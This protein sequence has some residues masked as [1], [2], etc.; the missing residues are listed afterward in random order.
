MGEVTLNMKSELNCNPKYISLVTLTGQ[1]AVLGLS[2]RYARTR[3][4]DMFISTTA[5]FLAEVV[6]LLTCLG[7]VWNA[8]D[9]SLSQWWGA[10]DKTIIKQ[11]MDTVKVMVPSAV[12]LIQNNLLYVAASNLDV[13]T[14][15]ITYQLKI[16]TTAMF[17]VTMLGKK[18]LPTQW[19]SLVLLV[20]GVAMVQLSDVKEVKS[21]GPDQSKFVGFSAALT[22]CCLSGFAGVYFEKILKG[23]D[24]SVW[25]RNVQMALFA[26]P[27]GLLSSYLKDATNIAE[28]GFM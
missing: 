17:A 22:A 18:L 20:A 4:G 13:A 8:E 23:S 26:V 27:M 21:A 7:L 25:M 2:M 19:F 24:V 9:R 10:L 15:Q 6:K 16:L 5:V 12:Y 28:K 11:P 14:Y 1:N 3:P